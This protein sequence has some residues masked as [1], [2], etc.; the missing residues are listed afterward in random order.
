MAHDTA[1]TDCKTVRF[2]Q[3]TP[4]L[5]G[6]DFSPIPMQEATTT[7]L[8]N[9]F[10]KWDQYL[11][12][13]PTPSYDSLLRFLCRRAVGSSAW[14]F[15]S[16]LV[17]MVL[18]FLFYILGVSGAHD[19]MV[20]DTKQGRCLWYCPASCD[21]RFGL[22]PEEPYLQSAELP[23][24]AQVSYSIILRGTRCIPGSSISNG[25]AMD[26]SPINSDEEC[27]HADTSMPFQRSMEFDPIVHRATTLILAILE[28]R[29]FY[30]SADIGPDFY[31]RSKP[32]SMQWYSFLFAT[33]LQVHRDH[34]ER[35]VTPR[36]RARH[37]IVMLRG[38]LYQVQLVRRDAMGA[39]IMPTYEEVKRQ[40][41]KIFHSRHTSSALYVG[42]LT[43]LKSADRFREEQGLKCISDN[44]IYNLCVIRDSL[45][46]VSLDPD[47]SPRLANETLYCVQSKNSFNRWYDKSVS[48]VV[49]QNGVAGFLMNY[50]AGVTGT[51]ASAFVEK[52]LEKEEQILR[53][54]LEENIETHDQI[55]LRE[56]KSP[57][58]LLWDDTADGHYRR[59]IDKYLRTREGTGPFAPLVPSTFNLRSG[60]SRRS[61]IK[62]RVSPA[63][64]FN[65]ALQLALL[66]M[67]G[68][69]MEVFEIVNLRHYRYGGTAWMETNNATMR[70][71]ITSASRSMDDKETMPGGNE[72][73]NL[74]PLLKAAI[75]GYR[76]DLMANKCGDVYLWHLDALYRVLGLK[77]RLP[78]KASPEKSLRQ[79]VQQWMV[80]Y[81]RG[82]SV[83]ILPPATA[84]NF[85]SNPGWNPAIEAIGRVGVKCLLG[86]DDVALIPIN[87]GLECF[88]TLTFLNLHTK[89]YQEFKL[90][91]ILAVS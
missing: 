12:I 64:T 5:I 45:F 65:T 21:D 31:R 18:S 81:F 41:E 84:Q 57:R 46:V 56:L 79:I 58:M 88:T 28:T 27:G 55:Q 71:F 47:D 66:R 87:F 59:R 3:D 11:Q 44:N 25:L 20:A 7:D 13:A 77:T 82:P 83:D 16:K 38:R 17:Y 42:A 35:H 78:R 6:T 9:R 50:F 80:D 48:L 61:L 72:K 91:L 68:R 30:S 36:A 26:A 62:L 70:E 89:T 23:S 60:I 90:E 53:S 32:M 29:E 74:K 54:V 43:A 76:D 2:C 34:V 1:E 85:V 67:S 19:R 4:T 75:Q 33:S 86:K 40:L 69:S 49:F 8:H 14:I 22:R 52:V 73:R 37:V 63:G 51:V 39:E 10:Y 24:Q 15:A